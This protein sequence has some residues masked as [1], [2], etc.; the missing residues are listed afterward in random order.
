MKKTIY[1]L[2]LLMGLTASAA[3]AQN[4]G[5]GTTTPAAKLHVV[6]NVAIEDGTQGAGKVLTSDAAGIASWQLP[7]GSG[8]SATTQSASYAVPAANG[9]Q[10]NT[11]FS[12]VEGSYTIIT[13]TTNLVNFP[14]QKAAFINFT[15]GIDDVSAWFGYNPFNRFEV[16]ID[17]APS[18]IFLIMQVDISMHFSFTLAGVRTLSAG[19]HT[20]D[21]RATRWYANGVPSNSTQVC[22]TL[23]SNLD[24]TYLN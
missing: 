22:G 12:V 4:V 2:A 17:G 23:S 6:G 8:A 18:G 15:L 14:N 1:S 7:T 9:A 10:A 13:N 21:V 16:F 11:F 3:F 24:V 20:I 5:I 19:P